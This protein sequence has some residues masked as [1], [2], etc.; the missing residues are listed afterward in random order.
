MLD[1]GFGDYCES[2]ADIA[3]EVAFWLCDDSMLQN[4]SESAYQV[5]APHA[6][7]E[8][9]ANIAESTLHCM[10]LNEGKE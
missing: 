6:S 8:I 9:V 1:G 10:A 5:G 2:P 4:M 3:E 7:E